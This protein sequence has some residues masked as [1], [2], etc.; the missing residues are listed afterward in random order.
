MLCSD[1]FDGAN[2]IVLGVDKDFKE[3][4][5]V[6]FDIAA[7]QISSLGIVLN[8]GMTGDVKFTEAILNDIDKL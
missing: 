1:L 6:A 5:Y 8:S 3:G 4:W 7:E 2:H